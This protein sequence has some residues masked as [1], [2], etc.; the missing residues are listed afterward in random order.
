MEVKGKVL[1][2]EE[3]NQISD[4]FKKREVVIN[5]GEGKYIQTVSLQLSQDKVDL[6]D[7]YKVGQELTFTVN[8]RGREWTSPKGEVRVFNTLDV[9][10]IEGDVMPQAQTTAPA[11]NES[12]EP[13]ADDMPF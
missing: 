1:R 13:Q 8:L 10:K 2:I 4:S 6:I 11:I 9:W 12:F 7:S 5:T 3:V